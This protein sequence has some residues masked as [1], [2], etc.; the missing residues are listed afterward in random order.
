MKLNLVYTV[1]HQLVYYLNK[2]KNFNF[3]KYKKDLGRF[4]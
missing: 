2:I 3:K 4:T 1:K